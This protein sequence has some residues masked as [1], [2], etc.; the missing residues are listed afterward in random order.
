LSSVLSANSTPKNLAAFTK[1]SSSGEEALKL[2][3][4]FLFST[5]ME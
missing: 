5:I 2:I 3:S 4:S 1:A